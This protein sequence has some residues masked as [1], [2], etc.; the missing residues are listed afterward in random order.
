MAKH[1]DLGKL[2]EE[3]AAEYL[4]NH[5][6]YIRHRD[7]RFN[8]TDLDI[9]CIDEFDTT[10]LFVEVKTRS[11]EEYGRPSEA[12]DS[13]KRKNIALAATAYKQ[14]FKKENRDA[15]YDIISIIV[16]SDTEYKI[17]H[18]EEAFSIIDIFEDSNTLHKRNFF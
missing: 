6:W 14:I 5:G 11:S 3:L 18:I 8:G 10:L 12:V 7:W 17:E 2:G 15:R 16:L 9:V 13:E 1:N 4:Q